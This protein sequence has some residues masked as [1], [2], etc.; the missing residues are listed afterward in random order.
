M[1]NM[2]EVVGNMNILFITLDSLRLDVAIDSFAKGNLP[3][4]S[5]EAIHGWVPS[6]SPGSFTFASHQ[7]FF[8]GFLPTPAYPGKHERLFAAKFNGSETTSENTF[9]CEAPTIVEGLADAGYETICI[10]GVGFFNKRT[11]LGNIL[12]GLFNQSY[13]EENFS[14]TNPSS[15]EY[16]FKFAANLLEKIK[17]DKNVFL[18]INVSAIH[19]PNNCYI[20]NAKEDSCLTHAAS[21]HYVD[22]QFPILFNA[23][24]K[25]KDTFCIICS[26]HG[27]AYGENNYYGH[28]IGHEAVWNVPFTTFILKKNESE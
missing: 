28:R 12:P 18:F 26:D 4:L 1:I 22:A 15:T 16:Q 6:H 2:N 3:N 9:V 19:Q 23:I 25:R 7:A 10:G 5:G 13:W 11:A 24:K 8:A 17:A 27:T 20:L 14:V 21:L